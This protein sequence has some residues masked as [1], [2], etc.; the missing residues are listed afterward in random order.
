MLFTLYM[1]RKNI[2]LL[3]SLFFV[4]L[5]SLA[6]ASPDENETEFTET[7]TLALRDVGNELLL[8]NNDSTSLVLPINKIEDSKFKLEFEKELFIVPDSLVNAVKSS[9][10]KS[11]LPKYYRVEVLKCETSEVAYSFEMRN[12]RENGIV[13]CGGRLLKDGCYIITVRFINSP[14]SSVGKYLFIAAMV[15]IALTILYF[16]FK[17]S[18]SKNNAEEDLNY[19]SIG[20]FQFYPEQNKL[21]KQATEISLSKKECELLAIF[22]SRPNQTITRDELTKRVWED[23]GVIVGRSL[24]TYI[25]KLR[26]ILKDDDSIKIT[27][28]HGVGYKLEVE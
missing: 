18:D 27:N 8:D 23:N 21:V 17:K 3:S 26:K 25:S 24:D 7:V 19:A 1:N 15:V 13:P 20:S 28:V 16:Y 5:A 11:N 10:E 4:V 6:F 12:K 14:V 22:V 9:F 2:Y